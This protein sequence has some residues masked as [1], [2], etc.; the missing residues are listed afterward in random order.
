MGLM[1]R[2]ANPVCMARVLFAHFG[3]VQKS[4]PTK[5]PPQLPQDN[6]HVTIVGQE[7]LP[8]SGVYELCL[9]SSPGCPFLDKGCRYLSPF[10]CEGFHQNLRALL[11]EIASPSL[12]LC[13]CR[14][15]VLT[16]FLASLGYL[17]LPK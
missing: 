8:T 10:C 13:E 6:R 11:D 3:L 14:W 2:V 15:K 5:Q 12:F 7:G 9:Y 4:T 17:D 1:T 16:F